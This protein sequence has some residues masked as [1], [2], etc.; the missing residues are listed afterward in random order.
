MKQVDIIMSSR[1]NHIGGPMGTLKRILKNKDY[2]KSRG[3]HVSIFTFESIDFGPFEDIRQV[4]KSQLWPKK[5]TVRMKV[6]SYLRKYIM[7]SKI[8]T[9]LSLRKN[10]KHTEKLINYYL[11]LNRMPDIVQLHSHYDGSYYCKMRKNDRE[12]FVVFLHSNGIPY[13]QELCN[14]PLLQKTRY[15]KTIKRMLDSMIGKADYMGFIA[16]RGQKNF[17]EH[18]PNRSKMDTIVVRN[19]I[20]D[21]DADQMAIFESIRK[22]NKSLFKYRLCTVGTISFRKGQRLII[23]TLHSLPKEL[24][25]DIHVD[26]IGEGSERLILENLVS[27]YGLVENISFSGGVP[28]TEV[29]KHLAKNNIY[30][31]M[32]KNEGLPISI[33]EAMRVG[34]PIIS[35][36]VAGIPECIDE[37]YNGFLLEP[38]NEEQLADLLKKLPEYDW[39]KMGRNSKDKFQKEFTFERMKKEFCDMYDKLIEKK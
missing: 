23:E 21:L 34:L 38:D 33:L 15:F 14:Y 8:L 36:N 27:E 16:N 28:N 35:T 32:S 3:Y 26:F 6:S 9:V 4:P 37:G 25:K 5:P 39:E 30:I 12:K 10:H 17:L 19:G 7:K 24:L 22:E 2:F 1:I 29:Y 11:S 20:D 13:D 18:Y 31:L